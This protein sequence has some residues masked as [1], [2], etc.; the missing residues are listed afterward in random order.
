MF[1]GAKVYKL[2]VNVT[3]KFLFEEDL[4]KNGLK[5]IIYPQ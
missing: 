1:I 4:T 3:S 5:S 2:F